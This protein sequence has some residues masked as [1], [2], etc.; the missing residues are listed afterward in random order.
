[1]KEYLKSKLMSGTEL[2]PRSREAWTEAFA[3]FARGAP[4]L[5]AAGLQELQQVFDFGFAPLRQS[6]MDS[7]RPSIEPA[8]ACQAEPLSPEK[9]DYIFKNFASAAAPSGEPGLT[10]Q[11]NLS[12]SLCVCVPVLQL[13]RISN[14]L[15]LLCRCLF[16]Y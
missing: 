5:V 7:I 4:V 8:Q 10:L 2:S 16:L 9:L 1:V 6:V 3:R 14:F 15:I 11:G 12:L 13:L